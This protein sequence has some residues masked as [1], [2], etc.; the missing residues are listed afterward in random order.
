[1]NKLKV[2]FIML[3]LLLFTGCTLENGYTRTEFCLKK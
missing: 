3:V 1:M 2:L